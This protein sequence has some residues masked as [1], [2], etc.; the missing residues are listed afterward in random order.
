LKECP[1]LDRCE[2]CWRKVDPSISL[3]IYGN[4]GNLKGEIA[5]FC[6]KKKNISA[7]NKKSWRSRIHEIHKYENTTSFYVEQFFS[8]KTNISTV[9]YI[10]IYT[11][12]Q[13]SGKNRK[14]KIE[15]FSN[16]DQGHIGFCFRQKISKLSHVCVPLNGISDPRDQDSPYLFFD[17]KCGEN[18]DFER[19]NS[20]LEPTS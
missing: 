14:K 18:T 1:L 16:N 20:W 15:I 11:K 17:A 19:N 3:S 10:E 8:G 2:E 6:D 13:N 5:L 4:R 7:K 9:Q 12:Y